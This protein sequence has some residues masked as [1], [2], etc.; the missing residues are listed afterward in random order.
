MKTRIGIFTFPV[1]I[2]LTGVGIRKTKSK[3]QLK[4][5]KHEWSYLRGQGRCSAKPFALLLNPP[6]NGKLCIKR[7]HRDPSPLMSVEFNWLRLHRQY[8]LD[9]AASY[10]YRQLQIITGSDNLE[11]V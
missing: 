6:H 4:S 2:F 3:T 9:I 5:N 7:T 10:T 8:F 11:I 1:S